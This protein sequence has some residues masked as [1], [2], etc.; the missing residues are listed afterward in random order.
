MTPDEVDK[1]MERFQAMWPTPKLNDAQLMLWA[2]RFKAVDGET[3]WRA[4]GALEKTEER[5]PSLA[6]YHAAV[7]QVLTTGRGPEVGGKVS[8]HAIAWRP[9]GGHG[10]SVVS[11]TYASQHGEL[12]EWITLHREWCGPD[13]MIDVYRREVTGPGNFTDYSLI[14]HAGVDRQ[15]A[16]D[17]SDDA[18]AEM[19]GEVATVATKLHY[20]EEPF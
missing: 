15:V 17:W 4:L 16:R 6:K 14:E 1:V 19:R 13:G 9:D 8:F 12:Q 10:A 3:V 7:A 2:E 5:R 20:D 11:A 18:R